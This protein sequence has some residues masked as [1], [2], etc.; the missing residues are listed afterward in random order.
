MSANVQ[1]AYIG[2]QCRSNRLADEPSTTST[3]MYTRQLRQR[4]AASFCGE[5]GSFLHAR[6]RGPFDCEV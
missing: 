4:S 1:D 3:H 5:R 2:L 6:A